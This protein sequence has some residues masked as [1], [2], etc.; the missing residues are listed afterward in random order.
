MTYFRLWVKR[1]NHVLKWAHRLLY[2]H[3]QIYQWAPWSCMWKGDIGLL[4]LERVR[5]QIQIIT[6]NHSDLTISSS[7]KSDNH[8]CISYITGCDHDSTGSKRWR[9][10][11]TGQVSSETD[12]ERRLVYRNL[13]KSVL[14]IKTFGRGKR[15]TDR[16]RKK[17]RNNAIPTKTLDMA[18]GNSGVRM[19]LQIV[20]NWGETRHLFL[21]IY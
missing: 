7:E 3:L 18:M 15:S 2:M 21:Q 4:H 6:G 10:T 8:T 11:V 1:F 5:I 17:L 12:L 16:Q 14:G 19:I 13:Q 9:S 20:P